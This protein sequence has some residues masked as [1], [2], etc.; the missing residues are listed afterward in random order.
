M[1]DFLIRG[2]RETLLF[3]AEKVIGNSSDYWLK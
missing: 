3:T 2:K 1:A